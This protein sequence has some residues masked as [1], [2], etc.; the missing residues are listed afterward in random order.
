VLVPAVSEV[1]RVADAANLEPDRTAV[2]LRRLL[3]DDPERE[4]DAHVAA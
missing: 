3:L 1:R 4:G 2:G